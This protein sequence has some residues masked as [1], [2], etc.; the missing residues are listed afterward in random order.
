MKSFTREEVEQLSSALGEPDWMLELRLE[1]WNHFD[2]TPMPTTNDEA[3]RR[4]DLRR[5][6]LQ[7]KLIKE[8][9]RLSNKYH[10]DKVNNEDNSLVLD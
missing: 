9:E 10:T 1:A 4:T 2:S 3:W 7:E 6:D 8:Y 5:F